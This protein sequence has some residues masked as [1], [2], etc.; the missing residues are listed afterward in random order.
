MDV[1]IYEIRVAGHLDNQWSAWF[2]GLSVAQQPD[3]TTTIAGVIL[4]QAALHMVL[5]KVR[6]L[7]LDLL[8]VRLLAQYT[9]TDPGNSQV[10]TSSPA[11]ERKDLPNDLS[12]EAYTHCLI[13]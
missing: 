10:D 9:F 5:A 4:N 8:E 7:Q 3:G 13:Q 11:P 12:L 6:D 1:A 2:D